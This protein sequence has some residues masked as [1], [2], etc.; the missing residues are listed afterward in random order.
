MA[1]WLTELIGIP[2]VAKGRTVD[3]CD[4]WGLVRLALRR[5][6]GVD[7][8][9]YSEAYPTVTD[10][11]EIQALVRREAPVWALVPEAQA[12]PGDV[13]LFAIQGSV[14]HAGL[15]VDPPWFLHC[16]RGVGS[17]LERWDAR[18]WRSRL[19][20]FGRHPDVRGAA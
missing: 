4:C 11:E 17:S 18:K 8:P 3:G 7:V 13:V 9:D 10:R 15:V 2:F 14:C 20:R 16:Q 6:Y 1:R 12:R 19:S 5:G